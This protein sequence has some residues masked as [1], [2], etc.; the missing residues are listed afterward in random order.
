MRPEAA[1]E[2]VEIKLWDWPVRLIHWSFVLLVPAMWASAEFGQMELHRLLGYGA[3]FLLLFRL[4]WGVAGSATARFSTFVCGPGAIAAYLKNGVAVIGHNPLGALSV[5]GMLLLLG[6][7]IGL[8]LFAQDTDGEFAGPLARLV[9]YG[10]SS[11]A[12]EL[13]EVMFNVLLALIVLHIVAILFYLFVK[14]DNLVRP[15]LTGRRRVAIG[16]A[17][18]ALASASVAGIGIAISAAITVWVALGAPGF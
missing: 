15:M 2:Q 9:S 18:P 13:H 5:V 7:Q 6:T 8:G 3:L 10:A 14:R 16:T 1:G 4:Y 17:Q 11:T 12:G